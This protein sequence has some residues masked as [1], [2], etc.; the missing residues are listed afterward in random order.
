[1][2][3]AALTLAGCSSSNQLD[4]SL[5]QLTSLSF[6][7]VQVALQVSPPLLVLTYK[8]PKGAGFDVPF[9]LSVEVTKPPIAQGTVFQL[10]GSDSSGNAVAVAS[11]SVT[12]DTRV[13]PAI[14]MGT[15]TIDQAISVGKQGAGHFFLVFDYQNDSSLGQGQTV[16]GSFQAVVN[17][18]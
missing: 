8:E 1:V 5:T 15:L 9:T 6:T 4:G 3:S 2:A 7:T 10:S 16:E 12:G 14:K 17:Q 18:S 11:R 13:F